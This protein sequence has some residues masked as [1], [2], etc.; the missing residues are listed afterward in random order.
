MKTVS[1]SEFQKNFGLFKEMA[2]R[3][4]I[5]ITSNGRES[6][7]LISAEKHAKYLDWVET[8]VTEDFKMKVAQRLK[9]HSS[10]LENLAK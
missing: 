10:T 6:V 9:K 8:E 3:E 2:Q 7:A 1:A 5:M 4:D